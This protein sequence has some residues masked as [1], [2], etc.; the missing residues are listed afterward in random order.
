MR[1]RQLTLVVKDNPEVVLLVVRLHLFQSKGRHA[2]V[3][4]GRTVAPD[5]TAD[6]R[7]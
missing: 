2:G 7:V 4:D 6:G 5:L 1:L 3:M